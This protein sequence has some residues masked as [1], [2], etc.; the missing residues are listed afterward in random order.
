MVPEQW[1]SLLLGQSDGLQ[2]G[3]PLFG[4][5]ILSSLLLGQSDGIKV[6]SWGWICLLTCWATLLASAR[7]CLA[8]LVSTG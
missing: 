3:L 2:S 1:S 5:F 4:G 7:A 6:T 8:S